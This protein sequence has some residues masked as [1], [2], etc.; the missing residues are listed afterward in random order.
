MATAW[1]GF[2]IRKCV[3]PCPWW[4][5]NSWQTYTKVTFV[6]EAYYLHEF[7]LKYRITSLLPTRNNVFYYLIF[8]KAVKPECSWRQPLSSKSRVYFRRI[9]RDQ[10]CQ[11]NFGL[12]VC[13]VYL[14]ADL[15]QLSSSLQILSTS[16]SVVFFTET[17]QA[18]M[19]DSQITLSS[20]NPH[21]IHLNYGWI[22]RE[23]QSK[24][25]ILFVAKG[26][27]EFRVLV[28]EKNSDEAKQGESHCNY[29]IGCGSLQLCLR[30][31]EEKWK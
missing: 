30:F 21:A 12:P 19:H 18:D 8:F 26:P 24:I 9:V 5:P 25:G 27:L 1:E 13:E 22:V 7:I 14:P 2:P 10:C 17:R 23:R 31:E 3:S 16:V 11:S 28:P 4:I 15:G 20:Q 29:E 6:R